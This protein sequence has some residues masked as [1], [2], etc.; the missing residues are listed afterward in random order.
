MMS[1]VTRAMAIT[2][3]SAVSLSSGLRAKHGNLGPGGSTL[4][5]IMEYVRSWPLATTI[6]SDRDLWS[7]EQ[8]KYDQFLPRLT[9]SRPVNDDFAEYL[10]FITGSNQNESVHFRPGQKAQTHPSRMTLVQCTITTSSQR[11]AMSATNLP[12]VQEA[13]N[14]LASCNSK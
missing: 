4:V 5:N 10:S 7:L 13:I 2:Q 6:P 14:Y 1:S 3:V 9:S 8:Y 11:E 12:M